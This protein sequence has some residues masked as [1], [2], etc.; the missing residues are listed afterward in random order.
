M[1][2]RSREI[3]ARLA[4]L[5]ASVTACLVL[6]EIALRARGYAPETYKSMAFLRSSDGRLLLDCYPTNPR[7]Y[8]DVD[9]RR[10]EA[11][12]RYL[13]LAPR[14]YD[15]V[16]HRAPWA[17][18]FRYNTLGFRGPEPDP[19]RSDARRV[20]VLGDSFT[21]GQG[22]KEEDAYP[23]VLERLLNA[24]M[25]RRCEVL[26]CGRRATDFPRLMKVF[27]EAELLEADVLVYA[28][29]PN[30]AARA[31]SFEVRQSYVNDWIMNRGRMLI[32]RPEERLGLLD[33]RLAALLSDRVESC[34]VGR[35]TTRWYKEMWGAANEEGR[36]RTE[37]HV[38]EM[39]RRIRARGGRLLVAS[40]P[41]LVGLDGVYPFEDVADAVARMCLSAGV[42]H[43]DLRSALRGRPTRSLWVHPIDMHPNET[44]HRLAAESLAPVVRVM[45]ERE[46][47]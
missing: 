28:L 25:R 22:V 45:M 24:A 32:G 7:G 30:D 37:E 34:R 13:G 23:R 35:E 5:A 12:A 11:R 44:A 31:A 21:E 2:G 19:K 4:L 9:L 10:P 43:H 38:R 42:P 40:W 16:S 26:N 17:V 46:K 6:F 41:L 39:N 15:V 36:R 14:R 3:L 29:V 1:S 27:E 18:E 33:S 20:V 8:F 47:P